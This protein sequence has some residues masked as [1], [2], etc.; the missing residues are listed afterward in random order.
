M[1]TGYQSASF[2][3]R[4]HDIAVSYANTEHEISDDEKTVQFSLHGTIYSCD[5]ASYTLTKI[6]LPDE[7]KA[8]IPSPDNSWI[9]YVNDSNLWI[10]SKI[11]GKSSPLTTDGTQDYFYGKRSDTVRYP[12]SESRLNTPPVPYLSWS[13][14]SSKIATFKV[15]QRNVSTL[16]LLQDAPG[17]GMRPVHTHINMLFQE[18]LIYQDMNL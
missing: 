5:L 17:T 7:V 9:A 3:H 18:I 14:D 2:I 10:Y 8:G 6:P 11:T 12:V 15:D 1:L 4:K 16:S 13:S